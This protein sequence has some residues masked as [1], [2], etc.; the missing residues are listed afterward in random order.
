M[1]TDKPKRKQ[2][3]KRHPAANGGKWLWP[4]TR[5]AIYLRDGFLCTYCG[6][7]LAD[8]PANQRT[9]DHVT[10]IAL[11]GTNAAQNL[12]TACKECNDRKQDKPAQ[13]FILTDVR[14]SES[15]RVWAL[16]RL[17]RL[18][19]TPLNRTL[20]KAI[21]AGTLDLS[22]VLKEQPE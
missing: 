13:V 11:G 10:P 12:C 18:L 19:D 4:I 1:T 7:N 3:R 9:I 14:L 8:L 17:T 6:K 21:I 22:D 15:R 16:E 5:L 2:D 20:A